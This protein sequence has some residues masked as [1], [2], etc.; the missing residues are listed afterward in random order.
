MTKKFPNLQKLQE[1]QDLSML[2]PISPLSYYPNNY[3]LLTQY[4]LR[5]KAM[6]VR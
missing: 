2:K 4:G 6:S 1:L 5:K 3:N